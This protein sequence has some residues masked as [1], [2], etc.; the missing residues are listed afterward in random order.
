MLQRYRIEGRDITTNEVVELVLQS[1]S[2]EA[3]IAK[4]RAL[5]ISIDSVELA[6]AQTPNTSRPNLTSTP[7]GQAATLGNV[8]EKLPAKT[9]S[10]RRGCLI[11]GLGFVFLGVCAAAPI[12]PFFLSVALA[13]VCVG[14]SV[15][16]FRDFSCQVLRIDPENQRNE[17]LRLVIC[18][19]SCVA[20]LVF[21]AI[22]YEAKL[23]NE[24][25][26][27]LVAAQREEQERVTNEANLIVTTLLAESVAAAE[28]GDLAGAE[29]N[30]ANALAVPNATDLHAV[31][32]LRDY[33]DLVTKPGH[34]ESAL[35]DLSEGEYRK[36]KTSGALPS[37]LISGYQGLDKLIATSAQKA[38]TAAQAKSAEEER[39]VE[40]LRATF[41]IALKAVEVNLIKDVS[42]QKIGGDLW[43]ATLTVED[44]WHLR[45]EQI[46]LQDAQALWEAWATLASPDDLDK[47]RIT[48]VDHRGNEVG[49]SR[50]WAG[51]LIWVKED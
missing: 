19:V 21:S 8:T 27:A 37:S 51:S 25:R 45:H 9:Q 24:R 13:F 17:R 41:L 3:A 6:L 42:V 23:D 10:S 29:E 20:L 36:L 49:G 33:V 39:K 16:K 14:T 34:I 11:V 38:I 30:L 7:I 32:K 15:P 22:C 2:I 28:A 18:S 48:L 50:I 40:S 44:I 4:A 46:R 47:A 43:A 12:I 35:D 1:E 31:K 26:L 5:G